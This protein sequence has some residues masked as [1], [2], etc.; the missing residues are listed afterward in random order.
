MDMGEILGL[1]VTHYPPLVGMDDRMAE[2]LQSSY[3]ARGCRRRRRIRRPGPPRGVRS[4]M[5]TGTPGRARE[6][7]RR[8]RA[9]LAEV[10]DVLDAFAP[11]LIVV[12]GDDQY[13]NFRED[14]VPPFCVFALDEVE[15]RPHEPRGFYDAPDWDFPS[16]AVADAGAALLLARSRGRA[17]AR[18]ARQRRH[19]RHG[20]A[21]ARSLHGS[22]HRAAA[23]P[24]S[25]GRRVR[26]AD[27]LRP[28]LWGGD[29]HQRRRNADRRSALRCILRHHGETRRG[30]LRPCAAPGGP[31][32]AYRS[33]DAGGADRLPLRDGLRDRLVDHRRHVRPPS[34]SAHRLQPWRARLRAGI[35]AAYAGMAR[36]ARIGGHHGII[37]ARAGPP[38]L[39]R[40]PRLRPADARLPHRALRRHPA[41][42]RHRS[43]LPDEEKDPVWA[44]DALGLDAAERN[45]L[46][47]DNAARL[48]GQGAAAP[49]V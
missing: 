3:G 24:G 18:P 6:H 41:L 30:H 17:D 5:R 43:S 4:G 15:T 8:H 27:A 14:G 29:R 38:A 42:H 13:E 23:G 48:L 45:L 47:S 31:R 19:R 46:L 9:A 34:R 10:R 39:L 22:R 36:I 35:A 49:N 7:R 1:G 40:H 25:G 32:S 20:R 12:W 2:I 21:S 16:G 44:I 37:A 11:G 26:A 33:A 28:V